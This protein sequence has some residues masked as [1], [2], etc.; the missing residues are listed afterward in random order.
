MVA[1]AAIAEAAVDARRPQS[2]G[3]PLIAAVHSVAQT[4][5]GEQVGRVALHV[6]GGGDRDTGCEASLKANEVRDRVS[7]LRSSPPPWSSMALSKAPPTRGGC[8]GQLEIWKLFSLLNWHPLPGI[9]L[10]C[11]I[12]ISGWPWETLVTFVLPGFVQEEHKPSVME[13]LYGGCPGSDRNASLSFPRAMTPLSQESIVSLCAL[14][15]TK[16]KS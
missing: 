5:R 7:P 9:R 8:L 11:G 6:G 3:S 15:D 10:R 14:M 16:K 2:F 12:Q 1:A 13:L 4:I